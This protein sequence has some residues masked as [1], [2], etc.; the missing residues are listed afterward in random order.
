MGA[1]MRSSIVFTES[2]TLLK[3]TH[4][5]HNDTLQ[6]SKNPTCKLVLFFPKR[7]DKV[8]HKHYPVKT[9]YMYIQ[10]IQSM[11]TLI[12]PPKKKFQIW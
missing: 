2:K 12:Q 4:K 9:V 1:D 6:Q 5:M 10:C 7:D 8:V 3:M 11:H